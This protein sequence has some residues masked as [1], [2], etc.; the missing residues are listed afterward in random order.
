MVGIFTENA[1]GEEMGWGGVRRRCRDNI[2]ECGNRCCRHREHWGSWSCRGENVL[3]VVAIIGMDI[4]VLTVSQVVISGW[5]S[6]GNADMYMMLALRHVMRCFPM[7]FWAV[8]E[9]SL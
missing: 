9:N 5:S 6:R 8:P 4:Q 3:Q 2:L 1:S 7:R